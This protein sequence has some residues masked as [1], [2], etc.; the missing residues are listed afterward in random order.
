MKLPKP[1]R[2][3]HISPKSQWLSGIGSG[4]WF[5]I[6]KKEKKYRIKRF[7]PEGNLE[8]DRVFFLKKKGFNIEE[9]FEFTYLSHC[10]ECTI[11]QNNIEYKFYVDED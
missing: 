1:N 5:N 9:K 4:S 11:I 2:P 7:S 8:C 3:N 6:S 10:K